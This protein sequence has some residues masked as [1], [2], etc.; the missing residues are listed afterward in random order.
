[1]LCPIVFRSA[2]L[3][4]PQNGLQRY[5]LFFF[6]PNAFG[7]FFEEGPKAR[8][9]EQRYAFLSEKSRLRTRKK[10]ERAEEKTRE[11]WEQAAVQR[12]QPDPERS[13]GARP[14]KVFK[15]F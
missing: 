11:G 15:F 3:P 1:M 4:F 2:P 6:L 14:K 13:E 8:T 5:A 9:E 10:A 12:V 7:N